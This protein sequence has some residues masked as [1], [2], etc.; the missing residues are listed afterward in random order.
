MK[1]AVRVEETIGRT[2]I[3]EAEDLCDA[4]EIVEKAV[5]DNEIL[6]DW[7]KDFVYRDI[8]PSAVFEGGVVPDDRD[9]SHYEHLKIND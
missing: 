8:G 9:V 1:Y 2:I 7:V 4:I 3:V 6:L 5:N